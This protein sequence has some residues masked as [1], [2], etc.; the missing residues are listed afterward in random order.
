MSTTA[1]DEIAP[2]LMVSIAEALRVS[3]LSRSDLYRRLAAGHI[4]AVKAGS[5]TLI[6]FDSLVEHLRALPRAEFRQT[7]AGLCSRRSDGND[8]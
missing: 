2:P 3:G 4:R 1:D 8:R 6:P 5:R 7:A